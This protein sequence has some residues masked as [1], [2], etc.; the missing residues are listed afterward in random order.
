MTYCSP[1]QRPLI[2]T[3]REI[4]D[5]VFHANSIDWNCVSTTLPPA[6]VRSRSPRASPQRNLTLCH[7]QLCGLPRLLRSCGKNTKGLFVVFSKPA[8]SSCR[9]YQISTRPQGLPL[10]AHFLQREHSRIPRSHSSAQLQL[11]R[12]TASSFLS[13]LRHP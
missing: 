7:R 3:I 8:L 11:S 12:H 13:S 4:S 6:N 10:R 1:K 5:D 9:P 2:S